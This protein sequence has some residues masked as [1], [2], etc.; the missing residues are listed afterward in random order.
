MPKIFMY[1]KSSKAAISMKCPV[2][3]IRWTSLSYVA[4]GI[5]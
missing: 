5:K 3:K 4:K 2:N 1:H